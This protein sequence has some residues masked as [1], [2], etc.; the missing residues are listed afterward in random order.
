MQKVRVYV[1]SEHLLEQWASTRD[2]DTIMRTLNGFIKAMGP[3]AEVVEINNRYE[4][5]GPY[6]VRLYYGDDIK[7][8]ADPYR[9][10]GDPKDFLRVYTK[11]FS[12]HSVTKDYINRI[13]NRVTILTDEF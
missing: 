11:I 12:A 10:I 4:L 7:F 3:L 5:A 2:C 1:P 6:C 8:P 9:V 13:R